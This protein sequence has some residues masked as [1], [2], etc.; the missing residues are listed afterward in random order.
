MENRSCTYWKMKK[1]CLGEGTVK[2]RF[3]ALC[4]PV[5]IYKIQ[6]I[7]MRYGIAA[8]YYLIGKVQIPPGRFHIFMAH[9][10]HQAVYI[11][12]AVMLI[13][14]DAVVGGKV[15]PELMGGQFK[16]KL[17]GKFGNHKFDSISG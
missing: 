15:V 11:H 6:L 2:N 16:G 10:V 1:K 17:V 7:Q 5:P 4:F 12:L 13:L 8:C 14:I 9:E 3:R